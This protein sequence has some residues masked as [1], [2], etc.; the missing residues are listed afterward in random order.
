MHD[1]FIS[2]S[3]KDKPVAN[4]L[5]SILEQNHI[6]CW[7]DYRDILTGET[8]ASQIIDAIKACSIFVLVLS[9][10]SS[11]S[12]DVIN[13]INSAVKEGKVVIPFKIDSS[14]LSNDAQYYI[15]SCHW[16]DAITPPIEARIY[17]LIDSINKHLSKSDNTPTGRNVKITPSGS[18]HTCRCVKYE[19]LIG[20]GYTA[21]SI[22]MQLVEND[23][24]N[25]NGI[26]IENEG[27]AM[28][29][30]EFL[31]DSTDTF[32]YIINGENQIVGDWSIVALTDEAFEEALT[33]ELLEKDMTVYNTEMIC[34]PNIYNGYILSLGLL[35]DYRNTTIHNLLV[36]SFLKQIEEYSNNGIF[37]KSWCINV[38]SKETEALVRSLGFKYVCDNKVLGKIY[39]CDFMPL[40]KSRLLEKYP[41]L[42]K[43]YEEQ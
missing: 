9:K 34:F 29:W 11:E 14:E 23:Y 13:E 20:L 7:I 4:S 42:V 19:E 21:S 31:Q 17:E 18:K 30:E 40:P 26:G 35:P 37:F 38:F 43:N 27:T 12:R 2:Y 1:I 16:L 32:Q 15:G 3:R 41:T 25:C 5:L 10:N 36:D 28:Q 24:I 8:Y 33:G 6:K 39:K 22:A